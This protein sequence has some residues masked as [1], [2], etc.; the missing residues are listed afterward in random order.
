M[1]RK[2]FFKQV[3][4]DTSS[5]EQYQRLSYNPEEKCLKYSARRQN[6]AGY[7]ETYEA[8]IVPETWKHRFL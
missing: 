8:D 1:S 5:C 2:D 4:L 7:P 6:P 3:L